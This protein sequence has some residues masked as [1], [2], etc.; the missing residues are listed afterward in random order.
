MSILVRHLRF[1]VVFSLFAALAAP[2]FAQQ[3]DM[4]PLAVRLAGKLKT[5]PTRVIV[6]GFLDSRDLRSP[7]GVQLA[8]EFADA[9][10]RASPGLEFVSR[11]EFNRVRRE[12]LWTEDDARE[13]SVLR[14]LALEL[15]ARL[16]I[17]G[18]YERRKES[19]QLTVQAFDFRKDR[20]V[21]E[22]SVTL[23]LTEER[24]RLDEQPFGLRRCEK[25]PTP[26]KLSTEVPTAVFQPGKDGVGVPECV[27]CPGPTFTLEA[28]AAKY[29]GRV[30][31]K[32]IVTPEG[33]T[34]NIRVEKG[35]KYGLTEAAVDAVKRWRFKPALLN[36][37]PVPVETMI[38][39]TFRLR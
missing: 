8:S 12:G 11:E 5:G 33:R 28:R 36:G 26:P 14:S 19:L 18:W 32:I 24:A 23:P 15:D 4:D 29:V 20:R 34:A 9:L 6:A 13:F 1:L 2:A 3:T 17:T 39:V 25:D 22:V 10:H 7:L 37:K 21:A 27:R 38:E 16:L 31:L 35:A 30:V